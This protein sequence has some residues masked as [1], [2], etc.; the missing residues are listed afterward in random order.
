MRTGNNQLEFYKPSNTYLITQ[1]LKISHGPRNKVETL[2]RY[3]TLFKIQDTHCKDKIN[4]YIYHPY[5]RHLKKDVR[6]TYNPIIGN[7][8]KYLILY[9]YVKFL[10]TPKF[11]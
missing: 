3:Y 7:T 11:Y 2:I 10:I 8:T 1:Y 6:I 9:N 5:I 4:I